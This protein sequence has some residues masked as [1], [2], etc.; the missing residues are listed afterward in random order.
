MS[1]LRISKPNP[2]SHIKCLIPPYIWWK[3]IQTKKNKVILDNCV[4]KIARELDL[5]QLE[6]SPK[7]NFD[8][9]NNWHDNLPKFFR[10]KIIRLEKGLK[11]I[12]Q[13]IIHQVGK[14]RKQTSLRNQ[15]AARG[16]KKFPSLTMEEIMIRI[17]ALKKVDPE[18]NHVSVKSLEDNV[19]CIKKS[20]IKNGS[21]S[22]QQE[23]WNYFT[24]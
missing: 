23:S 8:H 2:K 21:Y 11:V 7:F 4:D 20:I 22:S 19:F 15:M 6:G 9:L 13:E 16:K 18:V 24:R 14:N 3:K 17:E 5:I 12:S 10:G 1:T